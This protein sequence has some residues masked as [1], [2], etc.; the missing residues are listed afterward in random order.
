MCG[1]A[2]S[3]CDRGSA[4]AVEDVRAMLAVQAHRGPEGMRVTR[5]GPA[6]FGVSQLRF[7]DPDGPPQPY[8]TPDRLLLVAF[9]GE[10]YNHADLAD[11]LAARGRPPGGRSE[12]ALL[13]ALYLLDGARM[14][15]SLNG[16]F[17]IAI[18]DAR[19]GETLLIRDQLGKKPLSY[20]LLGNEL[21]F[22]SELSGLRSAAS[23]TDPA[24]IR[25]YLTFNAVPAPTSLL[26]GVRKVEH[27]SAVRICGLTVRSERYW[28]PRLHPCRHWR[29]DGSEALEAA[30]RAATR[31]RIPAGPLG[32]F[33]SGGL[34]S[35]LVAALAA[36]ECSE[37]LRSY[38]LGF[39]DAA[40]FD[41]SSQALQMAAA[42]GTRHTVVPL[43]LAELA[44][45]TRRWVGAL[46]EPIADHSLIPTIAL[47]AAASADVKAVLTGD[48]ADE[49]AMGYALFAASAV[50][51]GLTHAVPAPVIRAVL[52]HV[53]RRQPGDRNLHLA[54]VATLL[55]RATTVS[56][57]H[58][59]YAAAA[60]VPLESQHSLLTPAALAAAGADVPFETI[61]ALTY[62]SPDA[63][64]SEHLQLGMICHFLRDVILAKLDRATMLAS[65][66]ARS[67]FLDLEVVE[68]LLGLPQSQKLRG[69]TGKY[70]VKR[71]AARY[72][73]SRLVHQRKR[74]FRAPVA[75]LLR[76]PL[77]E[78]LTD[79][80]AADTI[81]ESGLFRPEAVASL[82]AD[83]LTGRADH[84]R[85][86]WSL[87]C[88]QSW[89]LAATRGNRTPELTVAS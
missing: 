29:P 51:R 34:D 57:E 39:P 58:Q 37:G 82:L 68:L 40:S 33:L 60:A 32:V 65:I 70:V 45:A 24:A 69:L 22:S 71:V 81:R 87:A 80:L 52:K 61:D 8:R 67:P 15:R 64:P 1:I 78:W 55:A 6:T 25:R 66:E 11:G 17:A 35:G 13:A 75:A 3:V 43:P 89:L 79:L 56:P 41:E 38:S 54:H 12:A 30:L 20:T 86:L 16:M 36:R 62:E 7:V 59:Y 44:T 77:R 74:G 84:H 27:G 73:P 19:R 2:G 48:G 88:L 47:A 23:G 10:I 53:G 76:G 50:F 49:L 85:P 28:T 14:A 18:F 72:L 5:A 9:N 26:C 31:R 21:R 4:S 63:T 46:D 83:H 42:A